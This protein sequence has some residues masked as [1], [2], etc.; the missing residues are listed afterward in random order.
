MNP[1]QFRLLVI[2]LPSTYDSVPQSRP[3]Q[4]PATH[5]NPGTEDK[6]ELHVSSGYL[7]GLQRRLKT[8]NEPA[9]LVKGMRL[10][11]RGLA[12]RVHNTFVT[13]RLSN[14]WI[15]SYN[16]GMH[17]PFSRISSSQSH[18]LRQQQNYNVANVSLL[19]CRGLVICS[20]AATLGSH[21]HKLYGGTAVMFSPLFLPGGA[22]LT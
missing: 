12:E 2:V 15:H 4:R 5:E 13:P 22:P 10:R 6:H 18:L 3:Q 9:N 20:S 14:G 8:T 17:M 1:F 19:K 11:V 16:M 7:F 21:Q